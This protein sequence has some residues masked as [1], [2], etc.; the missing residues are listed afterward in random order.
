VA[1]LLQEL[2]LICVFLQTDVDVERAVTSQIGR[3][4][5]RGCGM[6][7]CWSGSLGL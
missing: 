3:L 6:A 5:C 4:P 2:S 7:A 1:R